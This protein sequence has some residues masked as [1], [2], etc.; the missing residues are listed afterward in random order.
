MTNSEPELGK[1]YVNRKSWDGERRWYIKLTEYSPQQVNGETIKPHIRPLYRAEDFWT[2]TTMIRNIELLTDLS[3]IQ[4]YLP[5]GHPDKFPAKKDLTK[6][7]STL[8]KKWVVRNLQNEESH[9]LYG[10]ANIHG[11]MPP[12]TNGIYFHFPSFD[13]CT[14][15][16]SIAK[17]YT[18]ITF[19][20]FKKWVI[21]VPTSETEPQEL[22]SEVPEY[23]QC[24]LAY[25]DA[26]VGKIYSTDDLKIAKTLFS[27]TWE[28][29]LIQCSNL[30]KYFKPST[31]E[32]Y[33]AQQNLQSLPSA[34]GKW[35]IGTY[36]VFLINYG[37]NP[38]GTVDRIGKD[39][40]GVIQTA[41]K[42]LFKDSSS[43]CNLSKNDEA[44]WFATQQE[45]EEFAK[46]I[47][48]PNTQP[49]PQSKM[50]QTPAEKLGYRIGDK[51]KVIEEGT[52][53]VGAIITLVEDDR[54]EAP[55]FRDSIGVEMYKSLSTIQP[56]T[57][58]EWIPK[59][60]DWAVRT[61]ENGGVHA[62]GRVFQIS[63]IT[64][65][66]SLEE[67]HEGINHMRAS[68]RKAL[69]HEIPQTIQPVKESVS[70]YET[71]EDWFN[72]LPPHLRD[73]AVQYCA[74]YPC[75][76]TLYDRCESLE[77]ALENGFYWDDTHE[78]EDFWFELTELVINKE[79]ISTYGLGVKDLIGNHI[80]DPCIVKIPKGWS[81]DYLKG[82]MGIDS[83][84][85]P[86]TI[87]PTTKIKRLGTTTI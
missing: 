5:E 36:V 49:I 81:K 24:I 20:Q 70:K 59:V 48:E 77:E 29:V 62:L 1:W 65:S 26:V 71:V 80:I 66:G 4:Q 56:Y 64:M 22:K 39:F 73:K 44:K 28:R 53:P 75:E 38:K 52:F 74:D 35:A 8:P 43:L 14:T 54:S 86:K 85:T 11:A 58:E 31:K 84:F 55:R 37:N 2:N 57:E 23:V 12:Y 6:E 9:L 40:G 51:F 10:Y 16:G 63:R 41:T 21:G 25:G 33:D 17:G 27:M 60:G 69:P 82:F 13:S 19:D 32:A 42:Y 46:T 3:E 67:G 34:V 7:L 76:Y 87:E 83:C 72:T 45:A 18:E 79:D 50:N 61:V 30:G 15:R 78:C 68:V 47:R